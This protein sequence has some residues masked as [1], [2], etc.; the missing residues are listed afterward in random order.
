MIFFV[1]TMVMVA[2]VVVIYCSG[3]GVGC[4]GGDWSI[5]VE[6]VAVEVAAAIGPTLGLPSSN[7]AM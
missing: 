5:V 4:V 3:G 7:N 1:V 2:E 6:V